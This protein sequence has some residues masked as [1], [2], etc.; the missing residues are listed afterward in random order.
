MA[1]S[2]PDGYTL[3]FADVGT[4]SISPATAQGHAYDSIKDFAPVSQVVSS[5]FAL[6]VHPEVPAKRCRSWSPTRRVDPAS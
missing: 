5:P 1:K 2:D 6:V 4:I 3:L